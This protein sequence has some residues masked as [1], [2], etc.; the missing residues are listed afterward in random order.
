[1]LKKLTGNQLRLLP[2]PV[3][4]TGHLPK[5]DRE[6]TRKRALH[7]YSPGV[8]AAQ[9]VGPLW[10]AAATAAATGALLVQLLL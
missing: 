6:R 5:Q 8:A 4:R 1:V 7:V 9:H 10:P 2:I 3:A